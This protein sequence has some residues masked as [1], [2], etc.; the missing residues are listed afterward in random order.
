MR[1]TIE[2]LTAGEFA[3][4]GLRAGGV[5]GRTLAS[6]FVDVLSGIDKHRR[7]WPIALEQFDDVGGSGGDGQGI[8]LRHTE[9]AYSIGALVAAI[10]CREYDGKSNH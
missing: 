9:R 6:A 4:C 7:K 2:R 1:G 3:W 8:A 5:H 10:A